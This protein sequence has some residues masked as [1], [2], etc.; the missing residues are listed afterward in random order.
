M[1]SVVHFLRSLFKVRRGIPLATAGAGRWAGS[2][3]RAGARRCAPSLPLGPPCRPQLSKVPDWESGAARFGEGEVP[4]KGRL[5]GSPRSALVRWTPSVRPPWHLLT[6]DTQG[7]SQPRFLRAGPP[8][9]GRTACA[10]SSHAQEVFDILLPRLRVPEVPTENQ[11][12]W[13]IV[14]RKDV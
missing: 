7:T 13:G 12:G 6:L 2:G 3:S 11:R 10:G 5:D 8:V 1:L 14:L 4:I 9:L